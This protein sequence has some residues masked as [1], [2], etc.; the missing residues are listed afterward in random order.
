MK[1][2]ILLDFDNTI[3]DMTAYRPI[4]RK[5]WQDELSPMTNDKIHQHIATHGLMK[6][7]FIGNLLMDEQEWAKQTKHFSQHVPK[8]IFPDTMKFLNELPKDVAPIILSFGHHE[9]QSAKIEASGLELPVIYT[10]NTCKAD[11]IDS[12]RH[13]DHYEINGQRFSQVLLV[14]DREHNF[15]GFDKL[16]NARGF[17]IQRKAG[18]KIV[19][20][21]PKNVSVI[22][23]LDQIVL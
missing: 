22:S 12:W 4:Q 17:L 19:A 23:S 13:G 6:K 10:E 11:L 14:D 21:L 5:F 3:F 18:D 2:A 20:K 7:P 15:D 8:L 9:Y 1:T 16:P